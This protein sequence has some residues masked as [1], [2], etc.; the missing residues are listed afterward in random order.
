MPRLLNDLRNVI[1]RMPIPNQL[2]NVNNSI[3]SSS[4]QSD[5]ITDDIARYENINSYRNITNPQ[6]H[7]N[8]I[9]DPSLGAAV[10]PS[11]EESIVPPRFVEHRNTIR[12]VNITDEVPVDNSPRISNAEVKENKNEAHETNTDH[13]DDNKNNYTDE[14]KVTGLPRASSVKQPVSGSTIERLATHVHN[15]LKNTKTKSP[16]FTNLTKSGYRKIKN[17]IHNITGVW[18]S[19]DEIAMFLDVLKDL[20]KSDINVNNT[21]ENKHD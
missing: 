2:N 21:E 6:P 15:L 1:S 7:P 5:I 19:Q 8:E 12:E 16:D 17:Y 14:H 9:N 11:L 10:D 3:N 4:N 18:L 20:N 13:K